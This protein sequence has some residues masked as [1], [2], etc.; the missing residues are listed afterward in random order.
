MWKTYLVASD[1]RNSIGAQL[2]YYLKCVWP[3][4]HIKV[5]FIQTPASYHES[6]NMNMKGDCQ[7][8]YWENN[9]NNNIKP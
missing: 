9:N 5:K 6:Y 8:L 7:F 4:L 3:H 2:D 1:A